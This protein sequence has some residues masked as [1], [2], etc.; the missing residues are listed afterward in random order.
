MLCWRERLCTAGPLFGSRRPPEQG[1]EYTAAF[2]AYEKAS[3]HPS[4]KNLQLLNVSNYR[5]TNI[6]YELQQ[7]VAAVAPSVQRP[8]FLVFDSSRDQA[9]LLNSDR[10]HGWINAITGNL[11]CQSLT[12]I[13]T[14]HLP[15]PEPLQT[16]L[17]DC[18]LRVE[19]DQ[20]KQLGAIPVEH[21]G[22]K[23]K[24]VEIKPGRDIYHIKGTTHANTIVFNQVPEPAPL[25]RPST[26]RIS[27]A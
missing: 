14:G 2:G 6:A 22:V 9:A 13:H 25:V 10:W 16:R 18:I 7:R 24:I 1:V 15:N 26:E 27:F 12:V 19:D 11:A 23:L 8:L 5:I 17:A 4:V 21:V 3:G 20:P